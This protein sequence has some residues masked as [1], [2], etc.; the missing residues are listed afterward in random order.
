MKTVVHT[1]RSKDNLLHVETEGGIVNI[2]VGLS[3]GKG[4]K[5]TAIEILPDR[6]TGEEWKFADKRKAQAMNIRLTPVPQKR[7]RVSRPRLSR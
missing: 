7:H 3:D 2:R 1:E 6:Q 5:I 4:R